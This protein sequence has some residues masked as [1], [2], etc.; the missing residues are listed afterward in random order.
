MSEAVGSL[1]E[2]L[3]IILYSLRSAHKQVEESGLHARFHG[4]LGGCIGG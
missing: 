2:K 4:P 3:L 1:L